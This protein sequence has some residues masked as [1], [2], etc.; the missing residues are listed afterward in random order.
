MLAYSAGYLN[1]EWLSKLM[2]FRVD[3]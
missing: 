3:R 2:G 1:V